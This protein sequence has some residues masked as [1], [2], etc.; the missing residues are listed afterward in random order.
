M[1]SPIAS[2]SAQQHNGTMTSFQIAFRGQNHALQMSTSRSVGE[3]QEEI[4]ELT[5]V[6]ATRQKLLGSGPNRSVLSKAREWNE[7]SLEQAGLV[8][9]ALETPI[10]VMVVGPTSGEVDAVEKGDKEAE[11]RNRPRQFHPSMLRGAKVRLSEI[12]CVAERVN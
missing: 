6:D 2:S 11:K 3:L 1:A 9:K 12:E 7:S 5:H 10:K 4:A 8:S